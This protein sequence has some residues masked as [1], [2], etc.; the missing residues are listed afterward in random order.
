MKRRATILRLYFIGLP[1]SDLTFNKHR[2]VHAY[3]REL[4]VCLLSNV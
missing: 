3:Q 1:P 4:P 2:I